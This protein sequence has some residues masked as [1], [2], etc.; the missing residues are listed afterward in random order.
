MAYSPVDDLVRGVPA[1]RVA[2]SPSGC[3]AV[4][5]EQLGTLPGREPREFNA[6]A[7]AV[8]DGEA[9]VRFLLDLKPALPKTS[10]DRPLGKI[11]PQPVERLS[12]H[13]GGSGSGAVLSNELIGARENLVDRDR[14][15]NVHRGGRDCLN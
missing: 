10:P 9:A 5:Y 1:F 11:G 14:L 3:H 7:E 6:P 12:V 8:D 2:L 4:R 15:A 13:T